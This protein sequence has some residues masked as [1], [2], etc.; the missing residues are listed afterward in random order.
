MSSISSKTFSGP[1][2]LQSLPFPP[3]LC[4]SYT[5][6]YLRKNSKLT[7]RHCL[8][9]VQSL[10]RICHFFALFVL[11]FFTEWSY[12]TIFKMI[13]AHAF[14]TR[15][16]MKMITISPC[17]LVRSAFFYVECRVIMACSKNLP[18]KPFFSSLISI[19]PASSDFY[20]VPNLQ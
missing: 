15:Q 5:C 2:I 14:L 17:C 4:L 12:Q 19:W 6:M 16:I 1:G 3:F 9:I 8:F 20:Q 10:D 18:K 7:I 13:K 11:Q